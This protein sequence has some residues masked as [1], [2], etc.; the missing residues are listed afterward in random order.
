MVTHLRS[1]PGKSHLGCLF[2][3]LVLGAA[4]FV[5]KNVGEVYW[6]Y[7]RI[8]DYVTEQADFAPALS[9]DVIRR[10]LVEFGDSLGLDLGPR[11]WKVRRTSSPREITIEAQ[12]QDSIVIEVLGMRK[13]WKKKF[14][15]SA[16]APL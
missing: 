3:I 8:R 12:Y 5:G 7:Y 6:R 9:D 2:T 13:V 4:A 11:D 16:R 15:P 14:Q 10:R 1:R